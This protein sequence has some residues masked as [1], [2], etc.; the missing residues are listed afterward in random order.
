MTRFC[1]NCSNEFIVTNG[2]QL[3]CTTVCNVKYHTD[4]SRKVVPEVKFCKKCETS[5]P[6]AQFYKRKHMPDGLSAKCK[7]CT[8]PEK[9]T[10]ES[11]ICRTCNKNKD[12]SNF[13]IAAMSKDG[14]S[15]ICRECE[16]DRKHKQLPTR[17]KRD[18]GNKPE[19]N[20]KVREYNN[21]LKDLV[22][23]H[24]GNKCNCCG[25]AEIC[26]LTIDHVNND[27]HADKMPCGRR[28]LGAYLYTQIIKENFPQ[29]KYQIL[30]YNCNCGKH[31]NNGVCP[32][33][34]KKEVESAIQRI[35][36]AEDSS[37]SCK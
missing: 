3:F 35:I 1:K 9:V 2:R 29:D 14:F 24:Y 16:S 31:R 27:G 15:S 4:M 6:V 21:S 8:M 23:S 18:R 33:Q 7:T 12:V 28:R 11:K 30:C 32:H 5:K 13:H 26:F 34:M 36:Q 17:R 10:I 19:V 25:E 37:L 20:R 22:Y